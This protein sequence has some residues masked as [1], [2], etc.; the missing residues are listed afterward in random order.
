VCATI[1]VT[2]LSEKFTSGAWKTVLITGLVIALGVTIRRHYDD[3]RKR[4][5]QIEEELGAA[6]FAAPV[7]PGVEKPRMDPREPTAVFLVGE[8]AA[9]GTHTFLWVQRLFPGVFKNF[10][11]ASVGEIDTEEF[12]DEARW[13]KLRSDTK[14]MLKQYV[15]FCTNR[16]LP[17]T[18]YH[19]YGT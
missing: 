15:D 6:M 12:S 2:T 14:Q 19:D 4:L 10:V 9:S 3:V 5:S 1:L 8:S 17:A 11:F 13:H 7:K 18:Y 16:G